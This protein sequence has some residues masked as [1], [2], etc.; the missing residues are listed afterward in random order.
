MSDPGEYPGSLCCGS[1]M[2]GLSGTDERPEEEERAANHAELMGS[3][4]L[5]ERDRAGTDNRST[6]TEVRS[7]GETQNT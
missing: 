3:S 6:E 2:M 4:Q 7:S 5:E 1:V